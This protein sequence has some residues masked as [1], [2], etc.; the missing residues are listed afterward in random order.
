MNSEYLHPFISDEVVVNTVKDKIRTKT[1]FALTRFGDGE[2]YILNRNASDR[3]LVKNLNEWGYDYP[4]EI[5]KFYDDANKILIDSLV[6]SDYIGLMDSKCDIANAI[7]YS[8]RIWSIKKDLISSFGINIDKL[9]ICNHMISRTYDF[10]SIYGF[11]NIIQGQDFHIISTNTERIKTK[12][13]EEFFNVNIGYTYHNPNINFTNR[14][15][16][17]DN[18]A[19]IKEKI[20][21]MGVGLQKD[22]GVILRDNF[23]KIALDMGATMDAWAGIKSRPW[24]NKNNKQD[25]LLL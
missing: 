6:R 25:Y 1:P 20:V 9:Q 11:K 19:N 5:N 18:F 8:E 16:F 23:G 10:G 21:I 7:G 17:I 13:L 14:K 15:E 12:K 22:Y 24:F 3:F 2:I 4:E